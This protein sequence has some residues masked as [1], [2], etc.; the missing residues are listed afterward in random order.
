M[1]K[2]EKIKGNRPQKSVLVVGVGGIGG[3]I[4]NLVS[5]KCIKH[6]EEHIFYE[7]DDLSNIQFVV[8]D[9]DVNDLSFLNDQ[10]NI[11]IIQTSSTLTVKQF[12]ANDIYAK[13]Y[14]FPVNRMLDYKAV[15]EGAGQIRA[16]SRLALNATIKNGKILGLYNAIDRL[17][18]KDGN[19]LNQSINVVIT[20]TTAGGTGSGMAMII[21]MLIRQYIATAYPE[22]S[23]MIRGYLLMPSVMDTVIM[24]QTERD[25]Q[26]AN[27]YAMIKEINAFMMLGSG[28][29]AADPKLQQYR[30]LSVVIPS[31][32]HG[33][34]KIAALPFDFCFLYERTDSNE[35]NMGTIAQ[36][37]EYVAQSI[38]SQ[39]ISVLSKKA[40]SQEDN[41][42][43]LC[44]AEDKKGRCRFG[45]TGAAILRYPYEEIVRYVALSLAQ[46]SIIGSTNESMT[47]EDKKQL[48]EQ[49]WLQFDVDYRNR[50][51]EWD[52]SPLRDPSREPTPSSVYCDKMEGGRTQ[53]SGNDFIFSLWSKYIN[54]KLNSLNVTG[55]DEGLTQ[56]P[57]GL[58][59]KYVDNI[60]NEIVNHHLVQAFPDISN[61]FET[62]YGNLTDNYSDAYYN[63]EAL[64]EMAEDEE[65]INVVKRVVGEIFS[66]QAPVAKSSLGDYM[67]ESFV[68]SNGNAMHPNAVRYLLY[69]LLQHMLDSSEQADRDSDEMAFKESVEKII[70]QKPEVIKKF[71]KS[72]VISDYDVS[73]SK[74]KV[75]VNLLSLCQTLDGIGEEGRA[76]D[77]DAVD[78]AN[79]FLYSYYQAVTT[80]YRTVIRRE[81]YKIAIPALQRLIKSYE[82][83]FGTLESCVPGIEKQK[84]DIVGKLEFKNGDCV[85]H[86][87]HKKEFLEFLCKRVSQASMDDGKGKELFN[88]IFDVIRKNA[89]IEGRRSVNK[90]NDEV[91][92]NVFNDIIVKYFEEYITESFGMINV[93]G[94]LQAVELEYDVECAIKLSEVEG[95]LRDERIKELKTPSALKKYIEKVITKCRNLASPC[96]QKKDTDEPREVSIVACNEG[97]FDSGNIHVSDYFQD[98]IR[99]NTISKDELYFYRAL[100]NIMPTQLSKFSA[101]TYSKDQ[102]DFMNMDETGLVQREQEGDY[103]FIYQKYMDKL[104]SNTKS[105]STIT[106]HIDRRWNSVSVLPEID[107]DYQERLMKTIHKSMIYGFLYHRIQLKSLSS[108]SKNAIYKYLDNNNVKFDLAV[109]NGT[110]CDVLYEVLD[111]LYFDRLAV[112]RIRKYVNQVRKKSK[113]SG[114]MSLK[115]SK[116]FKSLSQLKYK[117]IINH[118]GL[119][120]FDDEVSIFTIV[121]LYCLTLPVQNKNVSELRIMVDAI[122]EMIQ[123]EVREGIAIEEVLPEEIAKVLTEQFKLLLGNYKQHISLYKELVQDVYSLEVI[124]NIKEALCSYFATEDQ[125][126]YSDIVNELQEDFLD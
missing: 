47:E 2:D 41:I 113:A 79:K 88:Q 89:Y 10:A 5:N 94:I 62:I 57:Q 54:R 44:L 87:F 120:T 93:D 52:E 67:L 51:M 111:A 14:W 75:E 110:K 26:R 119:M 30:D 72:K 116:F 96:I 86:L 68:S 84:R 3:K 55:E 105:T 7:N 82:D 70:A 49:S 11:E 65:M 100:Y 43:K 27:G 90:Y 16:I 8:M 121:L 123:V 25:S 81:I 58:A 98:P 114:F 59:Y 60:V 74:D 95:I 71:F 124:D 35:G 107:L 40:S 17:F 31:T 80:Y 118:E 46:K 15:S 6:S 104:G 22:A 18:L 102:D 61:A 103:F 37:R 28:H 73:A 33:N 92:S 32:T 45:S 38:Y 125:D 101:P 83:F 13:D 66:S 29:I 1:R 50:H 77:V 99:S 108:T 85:Y 4:V 64:R 76:K 12:L 48:L 106:P 53:G 23:V 78:R 42:L 56:T 34:E 9:T 112:S 91:K 63:V 20:G 115:E 109:S 36:Y 117:H 39:N 126:Y 69:V 24:T 21:G 97:L 19:A 122:I